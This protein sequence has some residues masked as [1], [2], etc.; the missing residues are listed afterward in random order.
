MK[1]INV[2]INKSVNGSQN[3]CVNMGIKDDIIENDNINISIDDSISEINHINEIV[4][5]NIK[6]RNIIENKVT[7]NIV[8]TQINILNIIIVDQEQFK[9]KSSHIKSIHFHLRDSKSVRKYYTS[10][11]TNIYLLI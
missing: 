6:N 3:E 5:N 7:Q 1:C 4:E 9:S 10:D 11:Y 2:N 8:N